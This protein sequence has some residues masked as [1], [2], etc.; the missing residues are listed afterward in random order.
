M[1]LTKV[2]YSMIEGAPVNVLDYG[3][4]PT[5]VADSTA[6]LN[7]AFNSGKSV[8]VP[9]G[10]FLVRS[11][12]T[13]T[14]SNIEINCDGF[15]VF[16][17]QQLGAVDAITF[18]GNYVETSLKAKASDAAYVL[19]NK[20]TLQTYNCFLFTGDQCS[21]NNGISQNNPGFVKS[22]GSNAK[23]TAR[24][25]TGYSVITG[26]ALDST[27]ITLIHINDGLGCDISNNSGYGFGHG[28]LFGLSTN[29]SIVASNNFWDCGNHCVYISSG[30]NNVVSNN[31]AEGD[32]TDIKVRGDYN[33][34]TGNNVIGGALSVTNAVADTGNGNC[35]NSAVVTG[36]SVFCN[37]A[38]ANAISVVFRTGFDGF[39]E[40]IVVAD[41][42][43]RIGSSSTYA[44][45][46]YFSK[47]T[48]VLVD[49]NSI[50]IASG[51]SL[52]DAVFVAP[53]LSATPADGLRLVVSNNIVSG[54][55]GQALQITGN[56]VSVTGN[57]CAVAG[58][59][60]TNSG[61]CLIY[62]D[63]VAVTGNTFESTNNVSVVNL[64]GGAGLNG[65]VVGNILKRPV[66]GTVPHVVSTYTPT[67]ANNVKIN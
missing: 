39:A 55:T 35:L 43:I 54:A 34:V 42:A 25:N 63:E 24:G 51:G 11:A 7:A 19:A 20:T 37:R 50:Q 41:N 32:F 18:T 16:D 44:I 53:T 2:T 17:W 29:E 6:A 15:L 38:A 9:E 36:N 30:N 4:D 22:S 31:R 61:C 27:D 1:S 21:S 12:F 58:G 13:V 40:N 56:K 62:G 64:R 65:L 46:V 28:I 5:G 3:A 48:N 59:S 23:F 60:G 57:C 45:Y 67:D 8:F 14:P 26:L 49:G 10:N 52:T 33:S 47:I 66:S